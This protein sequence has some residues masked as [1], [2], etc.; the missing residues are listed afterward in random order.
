MT[1]SSAL[2]DQEGQVEPE[3][4][5]D[6]DRAIQA[7]RHVPDDVDKGGRLA[8][9]GRR[10]AMDRG[11]ADVPLGVE[12]RHI[13]VLN[14]PVGCHAH[15]GHLDHSIMEAG[16]KPGGLNINHRKRRHTKLHR[17]RNHHRWSCSVGQSNPAAHS[18]PRELGR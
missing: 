12:Q 3:V 14:R 13:L 18:P 7:R 8:D 16:R 11:G 15:D 10:Q 6:Q 4:M 1:R 2:G 9:I 5:T 17:G